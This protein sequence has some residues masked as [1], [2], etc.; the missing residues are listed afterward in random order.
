M[1]A[2]PDIFKPMRSHKVDTIGETVTLGVP[3]RHL[4]REWADVG[5]RRFGIGQ[6][7]EQRE[8]N[9]ARASAEIENLE[10]TDT[11]GDLLSEY[12]REIDHCFGIGA[13]VERLGVQRECETMEGT[14]PDNPR[15]GFMIRAAVEQVCEPVALSI[16]ERTLRRAQ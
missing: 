10:R 12:Q 16:V 13:W 9:G 3:A 11:C 1:V 8:R 4:E 7:S 6:D 2:L 5:C 15:D 14:L